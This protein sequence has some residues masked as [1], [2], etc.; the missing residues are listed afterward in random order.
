M[1]GPPPRDVA[2]AIERQQKL[3]L[4]TGSSKT[5]STATPTSQRRKIGVETSLIAAKKLR[6]DNDG[7]DE[8]SR[9]ASEVENILSGKVLDT[10][11]SGMPE[12]EELMSTE[13]KKKL[14][15]QFLNFAP[16]MASFYLSWSCLQFN[17][18][19]GTDGCTELL[20]PSD[21]SVLNIKFYM[22]W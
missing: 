8:E 1:Q 7:N 16:D 10:D 11:I 15:N 12:F 6:L 18:M 3:D 14:V 17:E 4:L 19:L 20:Q 21:L 5:T 9:V 13:S 2:E 22:L